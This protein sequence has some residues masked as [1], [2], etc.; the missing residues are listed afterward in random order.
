VL[1]SEKI[2][3]TVRYGET[4]TAIF[5]NEPKPWLTIL[6]RDYDV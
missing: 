6:K 1:S 2:T 3:A 5:K 4:T